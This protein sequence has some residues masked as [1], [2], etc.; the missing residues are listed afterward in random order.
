MLRPAFFRLSHQRAIVAMRQSHLMKRVAVWS[1]VS[2]MALCISAR[3]SAQH[4]QQ[5]NLVSDVPGLAPVTDPKLVNPWGLTASGTSPWWVADNGTGVSTLYNGAGQKLSLVV[6]VPPP[7]GSPPTSTPTA[8]GFN[9][10][11][12]FLL[13]PI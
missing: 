10:A 13:Q 9:A 1:I 2:G 8:L 4:Y 5:T 6:T 3:V 11:S 12:T 7:L